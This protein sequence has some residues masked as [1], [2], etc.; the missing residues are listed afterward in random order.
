MW[1]GLK[2]EFIS[3][4]TTTTKTTQIKK[5][6]RNLSI[7]LYRTRIILRH[8]IDIYIYIDSKEKL[9]EAKA[10]IYIN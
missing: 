2:Q 5:N 9:F 1:L 3:R 8:K 6:Q 4:T 7:V 10:Y